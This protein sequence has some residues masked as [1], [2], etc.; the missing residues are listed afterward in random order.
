MISLQY[1]ANYLFLYC[2][3]F[4]SSVLLP[5]VFLFST[6]RV[7]AVLLTFMGSFHYPEHPFT[8]KVGI[9][10]PGQGKAFGKI[11]RPFAV[12]DREKEFDY[13]NRRQSVNANTVYKISIYVWEQYPSA[14]CVAN[15][16]I[17]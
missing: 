8:I 16:L 2:S 14:R 9:I 10:A 4:F 13:W 1:L 6:V 12:A 15:I 5:S 7:E 3:V 11:A 17:R